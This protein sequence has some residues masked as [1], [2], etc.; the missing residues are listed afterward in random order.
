M[1]EKKTLIVD[2]LSIRYYQSADLA[3]R[4]ALV[5]L[6]GWGAQALC[7][8]NTLEK[9]QN[10]IALDLPGFG[11]SQLPE[12]AWSIGE[13]VGFLKH[14][15][16]KLRIEHPIL[17]G[18]SFGGNIAIKYCAR[19]GDAKKLILIG[20]AG[21]RRKTLKKCLYFVLAKTLKAVS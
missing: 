20:S 12:A 8:S 15:F 16:E 6:H 18:H 2:N 3:G 17:V 9:C 4:G 13:Y 10:V 5:F 21:I 7:F 1:L 11:E 19:Y 14:F